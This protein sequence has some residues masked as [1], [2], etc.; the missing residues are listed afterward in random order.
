MVQQPPLLLQIRRFAASRQMTLPVFNDAATRLQE[1][2]RTGSYDIKAIERL[3][4]SDPALT[5]EILRAANSAFFGGLSEIRSIQA[6]IVRLGFKQVTHLALLATQKNRY[7]ASQPRLSGMM[8]GLWQ[9]AATCA[10]ASEWIASRL[11]L[12]KVAEESFIG[13]LLHDVGKLFIL[14]VLDR[15]ASENPIAAACPLSLVTEVLRTAHADEGHRLLQSWNLPSVYLTIVRD[16]H[17]EQIEP[18]N[19]PLLIVRLANRACHKVGIGLTHDSSVVLSA[20][21]EA[22]ALGLSEVALAE[23]EIILEDVQSLA[24]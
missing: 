1:A 15:M 11:R 14:Q 23:L 5:A 19:V 2:S 22:V 17:A 3:I 12:A 13:G 21:P 18:S 20:T 8:K 4:D 24:A 16:H 10:L 6:A 7:A 9:H